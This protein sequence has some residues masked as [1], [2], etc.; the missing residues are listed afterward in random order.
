MT[1]QDLDAIAARAA[2]AAP[3]WAATP[4]RQRAKAL[5]AAADAL[6]AAQAELVATAME[7]TGLS[8]AR[9]SGELKRTAVQLK[10]FADVVVDGG[11]LDVRIDDADPD[12]VL[13][14]R[15]DVRRYRVAVGPVLNFAASNF[16]FAFSVAGGDSAAA[17]AAGCP[18]IV[19]AHSGHPRL[20]VQTAE[21]VSAALKSEGAPTGVFQLISGQQAG[22]DMLK[23]PRIKAGSFTG[24]IRVGRMLADIAAARPTPIPF[25]GELG[26]VN[27]VFVTGAA[28]AENAD[29][30]LDGFIT[31]VSGSAGQ[32]CTKPGF[33][34]APAGNT[35]GE[36]IASRTAGIPEHRLLNPAITAGYRARRDAVLGTPG[37]RVLAEGSLRIDEDGQG[38]ATPTIVSAPVSVL[39]GNRAELLEE[40]FGP[41][42]V[43]AEYDSVDELASIAEDL[44]EGNLTGTVH[45]AKGEDTPALHALVAWLTRS[46]G[47]V[48]F[49][50]WPTGVAVTPAMQH[51]GPWPATTNDSSTSVGTAAIARFTRPVAFQNAPQA[52]L[53]E[54]LRD[55]N[56]WGV[57]QHR[58]PA[59]ESSAWGDLA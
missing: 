54:P 29:G 48:L 21:I 17:L 7:E 20:S 23:D 57:P 35:I 8:E 24:S 44:F 15:P 53:P 27:P 33:L 47:R 14:V 22:V 39:E 59:G 4:P 34:F 11:Y 41:L 46:T 51:G 49:G 28:L 26:S 45:A 37:V 3:L 2:E 42:S 43:I 58:A 1:T 55:D 31:S 19:K 36:G 12:F 9:L 10:L 13:G 40:S 25:Y 38:W 6:L 5:V 16:P 52:M 32:L 50:G 56:P 30:I 18:V